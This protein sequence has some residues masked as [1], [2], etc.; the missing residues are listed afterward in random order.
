[1]SNIVLIEEDLGWSEPYVTELEL[2][3]HDVAS[4][5]TATLALSRLDLLEAAD[6]IVIDVMLAIGNPA[7][8]S[9]SPSK[10]LG[11]ATTGLRLAELLAAA[12]G[13]T[14]LRRTVFLTSATN[15]AVWG[16]ASKSSAE[17]EVPLL[18]KTD[19]DDPIDLRRKVDEL[20][21]ERAGR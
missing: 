19:F 5:R 3:G 14:V 4:V 21:L 20:L 17:L 6:L 18:K 7:P 11:F 10:N 8:D 1:M 16:A 15:A 9:L 12:L 13:N 2:A